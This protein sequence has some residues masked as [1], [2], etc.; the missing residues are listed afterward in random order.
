MSE[1]GSGC[2]KETNKM[3]IYVLNSNYPWHPDIVL[4]VSQSTLES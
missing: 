3:L 4:L 2:A 1:K